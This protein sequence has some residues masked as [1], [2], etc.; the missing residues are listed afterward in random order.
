MARY[1]DDESAEIYESRQ[2]PYDKRS[3]PFIEMGSE[4]GVGKR[5]PVGTFQTSNDSPI[6]Q[7]AYYENVYQKAPKEPKDD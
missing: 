7:K 6:P 2:I 3:G 1:K 4:Y 5:N